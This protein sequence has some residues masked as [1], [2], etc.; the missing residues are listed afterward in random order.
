MSGNLGHMLPSLSSTTLEVVI[1]FAGG[2]RCAME[3]RQVRALRPLFQEDNENYPAID[4]L[5][6]LPEQNKASSHRQILTIR[7]PESDVELSV[8]APVELRELACD[9]IHPLPDLVAARTQLRGL[10]ALVMETDGLTLIFDL[11]NLFTDF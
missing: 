5:L 6:G 11:R 9:L 8:A 3:A 10:C 4:P 2:Q 7:L 1:F